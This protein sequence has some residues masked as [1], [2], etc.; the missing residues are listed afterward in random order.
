VVSALGWIITAIAAA[1]WASGTI[2]LAAMWVGGQ[3]AEQELRRRLPY[4]PCERCGGSGVV[5]TKNGAKQ[6]AI[7]LGLGELRY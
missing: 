2:V 1:V 7:C 4:R 5:N 6:C 3:D